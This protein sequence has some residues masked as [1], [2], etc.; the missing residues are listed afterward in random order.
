MAVYDCFAFNDDL[1]QLDIRLHELSDVVDKFVIVECNKTYRGKDKPLY[2]NEN[3]HLFKDHLDQI[4]HVV[5]TDAP[6]V[7]IE[8]RK[9]E[10][11]FCN[12]SIEVHQAN[13]IMRG[14][15]G[16][17]DDDIILL[18]GSDEIPRSEIVKEIVFKGLE[19]YTCMQGMYQ[20][21]LNTRFEELWPGTIIVKYLLLNWK[22]P[23]RIY[24]RHRTKSIKIDN[25]GWHFS[26]LVGNRADATDRIQNYL[27]NQSHYEIDTDEISN[28]E[29][30]DN[31]IKELK[32]YHPYNNFNVAMT[33]EDM[34]KLPKYVQENPD[35]FKEYLR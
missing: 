18:S 4:V 25:G 34:S 24:K 8:G 32:G 19:F 23:N 14:L 35:K 31:R 16:C 6:E 20:Y 3:K 2:F 29:F 30:L 28:K 33:M 21:F 27:R 15:E 7:N 13:C 11:Q 22:K 26:R 17:K 12:F 5:V 9:K 1:I 10:R